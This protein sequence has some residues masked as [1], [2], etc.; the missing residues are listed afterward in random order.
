MSQGAICGE[1]CRGAAGSVRQKAVEV[2]R[3]QIQEIVRH[4]PRESFVLE[5]GQEVLNIDTH[6]VETFV[7]VSLVGQL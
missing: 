1:D 6:Y 7:E 3:V 5:V 4:A 2:P